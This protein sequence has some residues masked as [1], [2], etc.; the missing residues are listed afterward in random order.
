L[1]PTSFVQL[2][3]GQAG[4]D[5]SMGTS[6]VSGRIDIGTKSDRTAAINIGTGASASKTISI[7]GALTTTNIGGN[8]NVGGNLI[9][10][11]PLYPNYTLTAVNSSFQY[12][13]FQKTETATTT[14]FT[15]SASNIV[16]S[17]VSVIGVYQ[18]EGWVAVNY[19]G[20]PAS[21][22]WIRLGLS[23]TSAS[24]NSTMTNDGYVLST[25]NSYF[26]ITSVIQT[27]SSS[28]IYLIG[29]HGGT[30]PASTVTANVKI[31]KLA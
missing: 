1:N 2:G 27:S 5:I 17:S 10:N 22:T 9:F 24:F 31:T 3:E 12:V 21:G 20:T 19:S 13:G 4:V 8:V 7:G 28:N 26:R 16:S 30:A 11:S 25:G 6:Q 23:T 18:V 15:T 14:A 29:Q